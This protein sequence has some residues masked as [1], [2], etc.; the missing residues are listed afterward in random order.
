MQ[1]IHLARHC[2][3]TG[4]FLRAMA[5]QCLALE[6]KVAADIDKKWDSE[7]LG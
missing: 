4:R 1:L 7:M 2:N 3:Q 6:I 5:F